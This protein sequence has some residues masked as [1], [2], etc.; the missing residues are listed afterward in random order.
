LAGN[1]PPPLTEI[2]NPD[3]RDYSRPGGVIIA[4]NADIHHA[5]LTAAIEAKVAER[6]T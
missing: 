2:L 1:A 3:L 5:L 6:L 4:A